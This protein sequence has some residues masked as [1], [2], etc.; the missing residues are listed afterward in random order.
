MPHTSNAP[1]VVIIDSDRDIGKALALLVH[2][3]G[4]ASITAPSGEAAKAALG[5][6]ILAVAAIV[7]EYELDQGFDGAC[8]ATNLHEAVG[9]YVP[10]I[11]TSGQSYFAEHQTAFSVLHKPFDPTVLHH[12]L[13]THVVWPSTPVSLTQ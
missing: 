2:D 5:P 13:D 7:A 12:W 6:D 8:V 9:H 1:L 11:I 4:Y 3:W 10:T